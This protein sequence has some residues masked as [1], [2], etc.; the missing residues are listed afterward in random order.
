MRQIGIKQLKANLSKELKYLPFEVTTSDEVTTLKDAEDFV[1]DNGPVRNLSKQAQ[2][3]GR[4][5][6]DC[7]NNG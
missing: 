5:G 6:S 1:R 4:M 7:R 2:A 3:S